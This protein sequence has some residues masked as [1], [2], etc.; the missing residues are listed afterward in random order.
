[1]RRR[2]P[3]QKGRFLGERVAVCRNCPS[4]SGSGR[5]VWARPSDAAV[6][7]AAV[8]VVTVGRRPH[9]AVVTAGGRQRVQR[10]R[11]TTAALRRC[12]VTW[13]ATRPKEGQRRA[14]QAVVACRAER[15]QLRTR[16]QA[17]RERATPVWRAVE[18]R[19]DDLPRRSWQARCR[20]RPAQGHCPWARWSRRRTRQHQWRSRR[21]SQRSR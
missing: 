21:L 20:S 13:V 18:A 3:G 19:G 15:A 7:V 8:T 6:A 11:A 10:A 14:A 12:Q 5:A 16:K 9:G 17:F 1:M 4:G 2:R